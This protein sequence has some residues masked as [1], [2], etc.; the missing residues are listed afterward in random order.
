MEQEL[1]HISKFIS[2]VLRH[3][4]ELIDLTLDEQGWAD[5]DELINKASATGTIIDKDI[6][7]EIVVTN[8]KQ[9][10]AFNEDKTKIRANQGHS[11]AIDLH[12]Q[13]KVPPAIL[14][15][16][17]AEQYLN[18]IMNIGLKKKTRQ[19]VHLSANIETAKAVGSRHG[20]PI[21]LTIDAL[22]MHQDGY[23]FYLSDNKVWLTDNVPTI[24]I[25]Q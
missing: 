20:K 25:S 8:D 13:P 23:I 19:H 17:T 5:V 9:R 4:P 24:Y 3:R 15:H 1:K 22:K 11:I 2:L 18:G 12:L 14:Y 10:F 21:I 16:G 6:L 7:N